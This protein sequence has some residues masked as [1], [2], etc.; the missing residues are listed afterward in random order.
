MGE[1]ARVFFSPPLRAHT[2]R[3]PLL[4]KKVPFDLGNKSASASIRHENK[5]EHE[6]G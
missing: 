6:K 1:E 5:S 4:L 2:N 3:M